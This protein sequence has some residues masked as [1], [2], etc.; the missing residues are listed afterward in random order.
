MFKLEQVK[1]Y[2]K[3]SVYLKPVGDKIKTGDRDYSVAVQGFKNSMDDY[4]NLLKY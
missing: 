1:P 2:K 4:N 3:K